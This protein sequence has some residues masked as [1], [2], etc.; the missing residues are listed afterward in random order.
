MCISGHFQSSTTGFVAQIKKLQQ[1]KV[2]E[3]LPIFDH[4][5]DLSLVYH[6]C[7]LKKTTS[8]EFIR[9]KIAFEKF[10]ESCGVKVLHYHADN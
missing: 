7:S 2:K 4:F 6:W 10:A 3:L 5:S 8:A 1:K 9:A